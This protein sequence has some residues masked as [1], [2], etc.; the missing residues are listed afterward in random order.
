MT[1][2]YILWHLRKAI[3]AIT[4]VIQEIESDPEHGEEELRIDVAHIYHHINTAWNARDASKER[5]EECSQKDFD[6]WR[7]FPDDIDP[8]AGL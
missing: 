8:V 2:E 6:E 7:E 3:D 1:R 4:T 5:I